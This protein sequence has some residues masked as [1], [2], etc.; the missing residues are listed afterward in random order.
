MSQL[1]VEHPSIFFEEQVWVT[2]EMESQAV[3]QPAAGSLTR[4]L[5]GPFD[6]SI[7]AKHRDWRSE[8]CDVDVAENTTMYRIL[9]CFYVLW[10]RNHCKYRRFW[11]CRGK[12]H[13]FL[14]IF[15][16]VFMLCVGEHC[17]YRCFWAC[18]GP[19]HCYLQCVW[20]C[21]QKTLQFAT[22]STTWPPK[23]LLFARF[24]TFLC[25]N[26]K[27]R[28]FTKTLQKNNASAQQKR[29]KLSPKQLRNRKIWCA[30]RPTRD[31]K[32]KERLETE[33][34]RTN[35]KKLNVF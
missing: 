2:D 3:K 16:N 23:T 7:S 20:A 8:V 15:F 9:Q 18:R 14:T 31:M 27:P 24:F 34:R 25:K 4:W 1:R 30:G 35:V 22:F 32:K 17:K 5:N 26:V 19:K 6:S 10:G 21:C 29:R 11:A 12:K 33:N 13:H 28:Q